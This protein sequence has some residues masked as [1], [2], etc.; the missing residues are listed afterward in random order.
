MEEFQAT[1]ARIAQAYPSRV[2]VTVDGRTILGVV[3]NDLLRHGVPAPP[4]KTGSKTAI[5]P[6]EM[7]ERWERA[8]AELRRRYIRETD[9]TMATELGVSPATVKRYRKRYALP[10]SA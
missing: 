8:Q 4:A 1:A 7:R 6:H 9:Q 2:G 10:R 3:P 5:A